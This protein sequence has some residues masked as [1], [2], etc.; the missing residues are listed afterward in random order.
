MWCPI[1]MLGPDDYDLQ[2]FTNVI[3]ADLTTTPPSSK[4]RA[5]ALT[6]RVLG[7][8]LFTM[9][10]VP[11]LIAGKTTS[12]DGHTRVITTSSSGS[13]LQ[14][15]NWDTLKDGPVRRKMKTEDLYCQTK[16]VRT[17]LDAVRVGATLTSDTDWGRL[18]ER[19]RQ[20]A[21][22]KAIC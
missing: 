7:P 20:P 11:A 8:F 9:L 12:P 18:G 19:R 14:T 17:F 1:D 4:L 22:C 13:Y 5:E 10:L 16:F 6:P 2:F 15:I 21:A 3:G